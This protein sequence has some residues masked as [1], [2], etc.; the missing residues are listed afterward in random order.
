VIPQGWL[1]MGF[2]ANKTAFL[3]PSA[4]VILR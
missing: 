2:D 4:N 3:T 1:G